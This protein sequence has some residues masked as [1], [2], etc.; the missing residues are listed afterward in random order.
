MARGRKPVEQ[1]PQIN[2]TQDVFLEFYDELTE[3]LR[4]KKSADSAVASVYKRAEAAGIDRKTLK[5]AY[6]DSLLTDS[7]RQR[8][9]EIH[10]QY[11][12]WLGKPVGFQGAM[13]LGQPAANGHDA[14]PAVEKHQMNVAYVEGHNSGKAGH[15]V[16]N[17][18]YDP[19]TEQHQ[20]WSLGWAAG[21]K[22]AVAALG[23]A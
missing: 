19:G 16:T 17:C 6:A 9:E 8:A 18:K 11:M 1:P 21:Q 7:E 13:D 12:I 20:Q 2:V 15:P 22:D 4:L 14:S 3:K 10:R 5:R 23:G